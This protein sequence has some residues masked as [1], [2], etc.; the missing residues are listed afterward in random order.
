[1]SRVSIKKVSYGTT[2]IQQMRRVAL[3]QNLLETLGLVIGDSVRIEL[4]VEHE[5]VIITRHSDLMHEELAVNTAIRRPR[6]K[7]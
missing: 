2:K 1:M 5:A 3:D 4:D 7:R 6:A